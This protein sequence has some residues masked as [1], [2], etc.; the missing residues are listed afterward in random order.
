VA[1]GRESEMPPIEQW[2]GFFDPDNVLK[3]LGCGTAPGDLVEFGCGY[4]TFTI[5]AARRISGTVYAL[6]IDP[7]LVRA[8]INRA[9]RE[10]VRN[11]VVETR[12]FV[13]QGCGRTDGSVSF[14]MLFNILHIEHPMTLLREAH[15]VLRVGGTAGVIH[16]RR[17]IETPRGPSPEIRPR[18]EQCRAW[19][20]D[21]GL[22]WLSSPDLP[23]CPWHWGMVLECPAG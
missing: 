9:A 7:L 20:E 13:S 5:A 16:W 18:P 17:D 11:V 12:D 2:E 6:D 10:G 3:V 21:A 4:G 8:T 19:A 15:R 22:R 23:N 1:K 14:V